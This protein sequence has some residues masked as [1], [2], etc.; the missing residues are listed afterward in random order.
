MNTAVAISFLLCL[1]ADLVLAGSFP[2]N[3]RHRKRSVAFLCMLISAAVIFFAGTAGWFHPEG[4]F[5]S[6]MNIL[7]A[8]GIFAMMYFYACYLIA[9]IEAEESVSKA[10]GRIAWI[11][12][13]ADAVIW[14]ALI[15]TGQFSFFEN[16]SIP[17][18]ALFVIGQ[19]IGVLIVL[20][21]IFILIR[22]R[23]TVESRYVFVLLT[24]MMVPGAAMVLEYLIPGVYLRV[25]SIFLTLL[26][27]YTRY[28]LETE[29]NLEQKEMDLLKSEVSL[30]AGRMRPHYLYNILS[31]IYYLCDRDPRQAKE[32]ISIFSDYL[33]DTLDVLNQKELVPLEWEINAIRNYVLLEKMRYGNRLRIEAFSGVDPENVQI[34]PLSVQPLIENAIHHGIAK[35]KGGGTVYVEAEQLEDGGTLI[36]IRDDGVGFDVGSTKEGE[37]IRNARERLGLLCGGTLTIRSTSGLGTTAEIYLPKTD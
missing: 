7:V 3:H 21:D 26:L 5:V 2:K 32:A 4:A 1:C 14:T 13:A 8:A 12:C 6:V 10:F 24:L 18:S 16:G 27:I 28:Q 35:K 30:M 15:L 31:T 37:G 33:R 19:V 25:Q 22:H 34:P 36:R 20:T 29:R 11:L 17:R 9:V 23:H